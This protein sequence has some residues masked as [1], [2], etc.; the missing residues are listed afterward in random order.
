MNVSVKGSV[1]Y[2]NVQYAER[3]LARI[4]GFTWDAEIKK[5]KMSV[6]AFR[7][8]A[9]NVC[10]CLGINLLDV[11]DWIKNQDENEIESLPMHPLSKAWGGA[12]KDTLFQYQV[13]GANYALHFPYLIIGDEMGLGKTPQA[14]AVIVARKEQALVVCPAFLRLN[15]QN[16]IKK[17]APQLSTAVIEDGRQAAVGL[18]K[19]AHV[20]IV[21][22]E[23]FWRNAEQFA[24]CRTWV[25]DEAH[26]LKS[27]KAKRTEKFRRSVQVH[28]PNSVLFLTGTAILNRVAEFYSLLLMCS[29]SPVNCGIR[30]VTQFKDEDAF[31]KFFSHSKKTVIG[32]DNFGNLKT[33]DQF[34]GLKNH[35]ALKELMRR[36]YIRRQASDYLK[37]LPLLT[38]QTVEVSGV[39]PTVIEGLDKFVEGMS[40]KE[41]YMHQKITSASIKAPFTT[42]FAANILEQGEQVMIFSD[43]VAPVEIIFGELSK[44]GA[45]KITGGTSPQERQ[46]IVTK[47]QAGEVKVIVATIGSA[48]AGFT[49]TAGRY[50]IYNDMPETP[51]LY[52][53]SEKRMHR[54]SQHRPV[55]VYSMRLPGLD[56]KRVE[57]FLGKVAVVSQ[58]LTGG[59]EDITDLQN[60]LQDS[61]QFLE[62]IEHA[63]KEHNRDTTALVTDM[64]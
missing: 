48:N 14:I 30:T 32:R 54:I 5:W 27:S 35:R 18:W 26:Y 46:N 25:A 57:A 15:W 38:R 63:G 64:F 1:A 56:T 33:I 2:A 9:P 53:Q 62:A 8:K 34:T 16:E 21:S 20:V 36:K 50:C 52:L 23:L 3:E 60:Y 55:F 43:H 47:F 58:T 24:H 7:L 39:P 37:G 12:L 40:A 6:A 31:V 29:M 28:K 4:A 17:F 22:Y 13:H 61:D 49:L 10:K 11:E 41:H 51:G 59:K 45:A 19:Q 44:F 42:S